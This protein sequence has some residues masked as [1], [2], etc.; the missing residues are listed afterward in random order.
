MLSKKH[1]S[2][3]M[4]EKQLAG[5]KDNKFSICAVDILSVKKKIC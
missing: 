3:I 5:G 4:A 2:T 1:I